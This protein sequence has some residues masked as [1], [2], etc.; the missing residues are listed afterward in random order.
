MNVGAIISFVLLGTGL[1]MAVQWVIQTRRRRTELLRRGQALS[2]DE[3]V[4]KGGEARSAIET[5]FGFGKEIWM[6]RESEEIDLR[7][8]SFTHGTVIWPRPARAEVQR[9]CE[10]RGM[11]LTWM[12][13]KWQP[14]L[15][16][17]DRSGKVER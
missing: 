10:S 5:D 13:V 1:V 4:A 15:G 3:F 11:T 6:L 9:F 12:M 2:L 14:Y 16:S 8:R 17:V 7:T